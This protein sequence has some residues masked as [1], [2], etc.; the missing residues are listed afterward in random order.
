VVVHISNPSIWE[1]EAGGSQAQ[2]SLTLF[3]KQKKEE[4]TWLDVPK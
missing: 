4:S 3:Q 2:A 1:T